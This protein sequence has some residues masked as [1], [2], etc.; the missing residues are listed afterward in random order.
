[1]E[2]CLSQR[3]ERIERGLFTCKGKNGRD[4]T[5]RKGIDFYCRP[6]LVILDAIS[7]KSGVLF[8]L[9]NDHSK[10]SKDLLGMTWG[11]GRY[12]V[13]RYEQTVLVTLKVEAWRL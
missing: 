12:F 8:S 2:K 11:M 6:Y 5:K 3:R 13:H 4:I 9:V 10:I 1:M 7:Q